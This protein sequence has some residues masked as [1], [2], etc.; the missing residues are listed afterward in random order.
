MTRNKKAL[1]TDHISP[2]KQGLITIKA[3]KIQTQPA[4]L[5]KEPVR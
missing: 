1:Q 5:K 2:E 4:V 3:L